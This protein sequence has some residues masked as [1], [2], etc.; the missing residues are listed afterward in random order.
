MPKPTDPK[1]AL[2]VKVINKIK[3]IYEEW[4]LFTKEEREKRGI[5][6]QAGQISISKDEVFVV[7]RKTLD[8]K[9]AKK[10]FDFCEDQERKDK[11]DEEK[12][13]DYLN[14]I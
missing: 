12:V 7:L 9:Y 2:V 3:K 5:V 14:D 4:G 1:E 13:M 10:V 11:L 8:W 6:Y